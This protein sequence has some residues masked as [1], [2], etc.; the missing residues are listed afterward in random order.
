MNE[1]L[2]KAV[3][4]KLLS[5]GRAKDETSAEIMLKNHIY[6]GDWKDDDAFVEAYVECSM[7]EWI[8]EIYEMYVFVE[9]EGKTH[10]FRF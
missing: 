1:K 3:K 5:E 8:R 2:K 7:D 6:E 9:H 10:V 4:A